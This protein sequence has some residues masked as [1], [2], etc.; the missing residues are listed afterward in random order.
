M[1]WWLITLYSNATTDSGHE[2]LQEK[3]TNIVISFNLLKGIYLNKLWFTCLMNGKTHF[4]L[5]VQF[6]SCFS[7]REICRDS[8]D[9]NFSN[10][11]Y[12]CKMEN[13]KQIFK[14]HSYIFMHIKCVDVNLPVMR[15]INCLTQDFVLKFE[16]CSMHLKKE[17]KLTN[18]IKTF[19]QFK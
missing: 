12:K 15:H 13:T 10:R 11:I 5:G 6:C 1:L 2:T 14:Q 16:K 8:R 3:I 4:E 18:L 9:Y 19:R 7:F 17:I